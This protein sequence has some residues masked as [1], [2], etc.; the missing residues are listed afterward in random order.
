MAKKIQRVFY[1][2]VRGIHP[3][4]VPNYMTGVRDVLETG[5]EEEKHIHF[6]I[7]VSDKGEE[8]VGI[9]PAIWDFFFGRRQAT[10]TTRIE[11]MVLETDY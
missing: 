11:T 3:N 8:R 1:V 6:F 4:D 2:D 7:P 10:C 5:L 9:F